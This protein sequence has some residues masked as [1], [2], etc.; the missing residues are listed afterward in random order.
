LESQYSRLG[1][2]FKHGILP[3][4]EK[5]YIKDTIYQRDTITNQI[6]GISNI[7]HRIDHKSTEI[8]EKVLD[9]SIVQ[10]TYISESYIKEIPI[11]KPKKALSLSLQT[12]GI[13]K[14]GNRTKD[15]TIQIEEIETTETFPLLPYVFF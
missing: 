5:L 15:P 11:I 9:D 6:S 1:L 8:K 12:S 13:D 10:T 2:S 4:K 14:K 7:Q 3:T